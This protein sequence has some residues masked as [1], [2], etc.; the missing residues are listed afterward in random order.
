MGLSRDPE[1]FFLLPMSARR[2]RSPKITPAHYVTLASWRHALRRFL[3]FSQQAARAEGIPPQQ[4]QAL[5]AIKGFPDHEAVTIG[6]LAARLH[7]QH[8][9]TVG[10]V[11]RLAQR[12]LVVRSAS[13][14]DRR[15]VHVRLSARGEALIRRL[16]AAHLEELKRLGPLLRSL[17]NL[18]EKH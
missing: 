11:N 12:Q 4:H 1:V 16:S 5:L 9:S 3:L 17:I 10:L 7:L 13:V 18:A 15:R 8:H 14:K 6:A 2:S